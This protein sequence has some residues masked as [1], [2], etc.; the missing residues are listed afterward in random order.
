MKYGHRMAET[1]PLHKVTVNFTERAHAA[2]V[3]AAGVTG[4][5]KTDTINRAAQA[6]DMIVSRIESG[7]RWCFVHQDGDVEQVTIL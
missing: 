1:A 5:N 7:Q 6:Y 4:D 3:H 2:V